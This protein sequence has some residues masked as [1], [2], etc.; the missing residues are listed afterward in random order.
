MSQR[1]I[2]IAVSVA[3]VLVALVG[4]MSLSLGET[5]AYF[6]HVDEVMV[7]PEQWYEKN[8]QLHGFV[9]DKSIERRPNTLDYRFRVNHNGKIVQATYT[10]IVPDTFKGGSEVVLRG[11]LLPHGFEVEP[12][13]VMAK[14]PSKYEAKPG[15]T[16]GGG[17]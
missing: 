7:A 16:A 13:G 3:V 4:L 17:S 12:G 14:C 1:T 9:V 10:G 5:A 15:Y 8:L 6:K 2:R 11:R